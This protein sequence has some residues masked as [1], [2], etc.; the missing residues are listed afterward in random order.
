MSKASGSVSGR[1][2]DAIL[3]A[4]KQSFLERGFTAT[5]LDEVAEAAGV[6]K[7]TIY[8]HFTSKENL[9]VSVLQKVITE[10]SAAGPP[11][12]ADVKA[13]RLQDALVAIAAD[14]V[15]TVQDPDVVGLR[16]VLIAEQPRHP[17]LAAA[18]RRSTVLATVDELAD[19]LARLRTR[20][21]I[22]VDDATMLAR[23]LLWMLIGDP[24]DAALLTPDAERT[25][26]TVHASQAVRTVLAAYG[27][28]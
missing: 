23:Q 17:E 5:N 2:R 4:A 12:D 8:S 20:G 3:V 7:M 1:K 10:R 24:L 15:A 19:Y 6:S 25:S 27:R 26:A 16:R 11:L 28:P 9:F 13:S 18:W 21:L 22:A 14:I